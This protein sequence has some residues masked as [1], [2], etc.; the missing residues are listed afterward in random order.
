MSQAQASWNVKEYNYHK[1]A[2]LHH[3]TRCHNMSV[4]FSAQIQLL[5]QWNYTQSWSIYSPGLSV[6]F[7][8]LPVLV[9]SSWR[10]SLLISIRSR[11]KSGLKIS[12]CTL[13]LLREQKLCLNLEDSILMQLNVCR[14]IVICDR[15]GI[16]CAG[17]VQLNLTW[18]TQSQQKPNVQADVILNPFQ[19]I[20]QYQIL[21][22]Y[23][24]V[25][26][27]S[28]VL[29]SILFLQRILWQAWEWF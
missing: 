21:K 25:L 14:H 9:S 3:Q 10:L 23:H 4:F 27:Y 20:I 17:S 24:K 6:P 22:L 28:I 18:Q 1:A 8:F 11:S 26:F 12:P 7:L 13:Q 16:G 19:V 5:F 29:Y 2:E 15:D